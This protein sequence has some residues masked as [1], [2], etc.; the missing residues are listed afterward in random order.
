MIAGRD[1]LLFGLLISCLA[2]SNAS[3]DNWPGFKGASGRGV[4]NETNL[5]TKWSE[6]EN[7]AWKLDLPGRGASSPV[8]TSDRVYVTT[9]TED[10]GLWVI[11][12]DRKNGQIVW[13]KN[14]GQGVLVG[15]GPPNLFRHR[16]NGA[17]PTP[18]ADENHVWAFFGTGHLVCLD[19]AGEVVWQRDMAEEFGAYDIKFG[20]A[21]S[22]RLWG[23]LIYVSCMHKGPSYVVAFDKNTGDEVWFAARDLPAV[24]DGVDAYTSPVVLESEEGD[25]LV[26]AGADHVNAYD[27]LTGEQ[28][29]ISAGLKVKSEYGRLNASPAVGDGVIVCAT[30]GESCIT[31]RTGG[32]GDVTETH[33]LWDYTNLADCPTPT[34]HNSI[35]YVPR[36]DGTGRAFE[37]ESG[38]ELWEKR[39]GGKEYRASPIVADGKVY[40]L[41]KEGI[42]T[43]IEEGP[44]FKIVSKNE[45]PGDFYATPAFSD[46]N[47]F[48]R[49]NTQLFAVGPANN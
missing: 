3:A 30:R 43:I 27:L 6:T 31:V 17:T 44:K 46:G 15:Y 14:V 48:L 39:L 38:K 12:V 21:S 9:Q 2:A 35:V 42:C 11:S 36:D 49:S 37:A 22:P 40:M 47:I 7:L 28:I 4:S 32:K 10:D 20:M 8:V 45:L 26:V 19:K 23:D 13:E 18:S 1:A 33:R 29:W 25:Q 41:S 5:P 16:H 24:A 34:I